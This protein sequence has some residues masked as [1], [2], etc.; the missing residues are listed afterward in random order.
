MSSRRP[1]LAE[2]ASLSETWISAAFGISLI[3]TILA[4]EDASSSKRSILFQLAHFQYS[5]ELSYSRLFESQSQPN[6]REREKWS[7]SP[8]LMMSADAHSLLV[9]AA[10][11]WKS[12]ETL[13]ELMPY[14]DLLKLLE[15]L[16][17]PIREIRTARNHME[18]ISERI[19]AGRRKRKAVTPMSATDFQEAIGRLQFP[20]IE[21]G[22]EAFDLAAIAEL[23]VSSGRKVAPALQRLYDSAKQNYFDSIAPGASLM[24]PGEIR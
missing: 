1:N 14:P 17:Q 13:S 15:D 12:M 2:V 19:V 7:F 5:T 6:P 16:E 9:S 11:F 10:G 23:I 21:F 18:H 22:K 20:V 4:E 3:H 8:L 24:G